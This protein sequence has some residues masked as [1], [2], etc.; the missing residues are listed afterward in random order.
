MNREHVEICHVQVT[1]KCNRKKNE[2]R[3]FLTCPPRKN[4]SP[5][6]FHH[7]LRHRQREINYPPVVSLENLF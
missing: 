2:S 4:Y 6:S 1:G 7:P 5:G 3:H